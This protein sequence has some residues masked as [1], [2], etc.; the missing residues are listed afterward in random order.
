MKNLEKSLSKQS[1][2]VDTDTGR[3]GRVIGPDTSVSP[4]HKYTLDTLLC[5]HPTFSTF[6]ILCVRTPL[7]CHMSPLQRCRRNG[8][9]HWFC[10]ARHMTRFVMTSGPT[11][12]YHPT[13]DTSGATLRRVLG[14]WLD[15]PTRKERGWGE[16]RHR[17]TQSWFCC[18]RFICAWVG[19]CVN[20]YV[21]QAEFVERLSDWSGSFLK[22]LSLVGC[23]NVTD[24]ALR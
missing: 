20:V 19:V 13:Q 14:H 17:W 15:P 21:L 18:Y 7:S 1:Q 9:T 5:W 4:W 11:S 22:T 10:N 12:K 2:Q 23:V 6:S 3:L 8:I 16:S 24:S